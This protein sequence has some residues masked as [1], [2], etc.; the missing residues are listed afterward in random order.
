M[1]RTTR[2]AFWWG[3]MLLLLG[4]CGSSSSSADGAF[5]GASWVGTETTMVACDGQSDTSSEP[6]MITFGAEG[7]GI[8]YTSG[9]CTFAFSVTGDTATLSNVPFTCTETANGSMTD[10]TFTTYTLTSSNGTALSGSA[11]GTGM[12]DGV[13]CTFTVMLTSSR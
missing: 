5:T 7:S 2:I 4:G 12:V 8:E 13:A 10:L 1:F 6:S 9:G 3:P 11:T